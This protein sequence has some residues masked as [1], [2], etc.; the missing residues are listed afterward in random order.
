MS[1]IFYLIKQ[2]LS[3]V[4]RIFQ[5]AS[6]SSRIV[7]LVFAAVI[8]CVMILEF[9]GFYKAFQF[10]SEQ[11]FFGPPLTLFMLEEFFLLVSVLFVLSS[12]AA[13]FFLYF[14]SRDMGL[15]FSS[16]VPV[17]TI[18]YLKFW[19]TAIVSSWS[20][21]VL[22]LPLIFAFG[23]G[24]NEN[25]VYYV[26]SFFAMAFLIF[27]LSVASSIL[28]FLIAGVIKRIGLRLFS[29]I[30]LVFLVGL[31][32]FLLN[33]F[34]PQ[35]SFL[36]RIFEAENLDAGVATTKYIESVF[37]YFPSHWLA[38]VVFNGGSGILSSFSFLAVMILA[39]FL[40]WFIVK[41]TAGVFYPAMILERNERTFFVNAASLVLS[42]AVSRRRRAVSF[43]RLFRGQTGALMEKDFLT[44]FR[45]F[46]E[47]SRLVFILFLLLFYLLAIFA[48]SRRL[49]H[50]QPG[51]ENILFSVH[52]VAVSYFAAILSLRFVF[53][54]I[55]LEGRSAWAVW[56][57]PL[58]RSRLI[59]SKFLFF[60]GLLFLA[61]EFMLILTAYPL[62]MSFS[63]IFYASFLLAFLI[64]LIVSFSLLLG[65]L[66]PDFRESNVDVLSTSL[67][68]ILATAGSLFFGVFLGF[69]NYA[70]LSGFGGI[71]GFAWFSAAVILSF[72]A[73]AINLAV[74]IKRIRLLEVA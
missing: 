51:T 23:V 38:M 72:A 24:H 62:G 29:V 58:D 14:R 74:G 18:F 55:S 68:G 54:S 59:L 28:D 63:L 36:S 8:G 25:F 48:A 37:S 40:S 19:E 11:P 71:S 27:L 43:P 70:V 13:G 64:M 22:G 56:S 69:F 49:G 16:P 41:K 3:F 26:F 21:V 52:L 61:A 2:R 66:F 6:R 35:T 30:A 4:S 60:S 34:V 7:F 17:L 45:N 31:G 15:F 42:G 47:W 33:F 9:L 46:S 57:A 50:F 44:I 39:G 73:V 32:Y 5:S 65:V 53:P 67:G 10:L 12:V 20:F 1:L